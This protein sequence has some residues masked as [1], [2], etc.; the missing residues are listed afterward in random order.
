METKTWTDP[1]VEEIRAI[2]EEL[3]RE[4]NYDLRQLHERLMQSQKRHGPRLFRKD[5]TGNVEGEK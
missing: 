2:R 5:Q 1:I 4:A 3:F